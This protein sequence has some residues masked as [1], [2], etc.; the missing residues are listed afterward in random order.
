MYCRNNSLFN[1]TLKIATVHYWPFILNGG[2]CAQRICNVE[3]TSIGRV[4]M[5]PTLPS[6]AAPVTT[7]LALWQLLVFILI[8]PYPDNKVH[9]ANM[10][11]TWV[12]SAPDGPHV[13]PMNLAIRVIMPPTLQLHLPQ[14]F[15]N[16]IQT[17]K[18]IWLHERAEMDVEGLGLLHQL[19]AIS[20]D[21]LEGIARDSFDGQGRLKWQKCL[22]MLKG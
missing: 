15:Q 11:P 22:T 1:C 2:F 18:V 20:R 5:M 4:V 21:Q 19:R 9:G 6:L 14:R 7:K 16:T 13:G 3:T 17:F 12:L 10:G 8:F